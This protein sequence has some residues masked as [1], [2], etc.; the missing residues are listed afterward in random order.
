MQNKLILLLFSSLLFSSQLQAQTKL[1]NIQWSNSELSSMPKNFI[2]YN[3]KLFFAAAG[4]NYG[5][6]LWVSDGTGSGTQ[7]FTDL[8]PGSGNA[9]PKNLLVFNSELYFI[10]DDG[11]SGQQVFKT[12]G[13]P[14]QIQKLTS[15]TDKTI[16]RLTQVGNHLFFTITDNGNL[17]V[18]KTDGTRS[19]TLLVKDKI[20]TYSNVTSYEGSCNGLFLFESYVSDNLMWR[21]DGTAAG[22]Y[23]VTAQLDGS[24]S[25]FD[26]FGGGGSF[27][28]SQHILFNNQLYFVGR[29]HVFGSSLSIGIMKTDGNPNTNVPLATV[30]E[31][32]ISFGSVAR[33]GQKL[34]FSFFEAD[35]QR[36]FIWETDG[37]PAGTVKIYDNK[38]T[39]YF[40]PSD[41]LVQEGKLLF[42]GPGDNGSGTSL[43]SYNPQ[44]SQVTHIAQV[45]AN[46]VKPYNIYGS[47]DMNT[48]K[49]FSLKPG[50]V[51][52]G[53]S[54]PNYLDVRD[55]VVLD[56]V[57]GGSIKAPALTY[58][59][60]FYPFNDRFYFPGLATDSGL[61]LWSSNESL[62]N[63]GL[64][65]NINQGKTGLYTQEV[66]SFGD[67]IIFD[68]THRESGAGRELWHYNTG[69]Q[70]TALLADINPGTASSGPHQFVRFR[71]KLYFIALQQETGRELWAT[72]GTT[73]GTVLLSDYSRDS[74]SQSP[75]LLTNHADQNLYYVIYND[76]YRCFLMKTD[77]TTTTTVK[78][79]GVNKYNSPFTITAINAAGSNLFFTTE[80][81]GTDL[82]VS[83]GTDAGT[84]KLKDFCNIRNMTYSNG[85]LYFTASREGDCNGKTNLWKSDG[86]ID[87]TVPVFGAAT[88][89]FANAASLFAYKDALYFVA[90]TN[91][92][93]AELWRTDGTA[94]G[95]A[96]VKDIAPGALSAISKPHFAVWQDKLYFAADDGTYGTELWQTD[97]T[98]GNTRLV[99]NIAAGASPAMPQHLTPAGDKLYFNATTPDTGSELWVTDGQ[100]ATLAAEMV[101]GANHSDPTNLLL[102]NGKLYFMANSA[103]A[104]RQLWVLSDGKVTGVNDDLL[105]KNLL[106]FPNPATTHINYR[107]E[108]VKREKVEHVS[109]LDMQGRQYNFGAAAANE[110]TLYIGN[111]PQG[112]YVLVF[113]IGKERVTRKFV[114]L[115]M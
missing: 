70:T 108:T 87:G 104:G 38:A 97:G 58:A 62:D 32:F 77:G 78:D 9:S 24:G 112:I 46:T 37:T 113:Q 80:G 110:G 56:I 12:N 67:H 91:A 6:E 22:T 26:G 27:M 15:F 71:D 16:P 94:A 18:W 11:I 100:T 5:E 82:W 60:T 76:V 17:S 88:E 33:L 41:L 36:L 89:P 20:T 45:E 107:F 30:H 47:L 72:D 84:F 48:N 111:L 2:E 115:H 105:D 50:K 21:S 103:D 19:G 43:L 7:Q 49:L 25:G 31:G 75:D 29:G 59:K 69:P 61:E 14:A 65:K 23:P 4:D 102:V 74:R 99:A 44:T 64:V 10:A 95:T 96:M 66:V 3:G 63:Y 86:T 92:A 79:I 81:D 109:V 28:F 52:L 34:Y 98:A 35:Q 73:S 42:T 57:N 114:K 101:P 83:N 85:N 40:S 54:K 93:G 90:H 13:N 106:V 8:H 39:L 53:L 68:A 51:V 55:Y 1:T